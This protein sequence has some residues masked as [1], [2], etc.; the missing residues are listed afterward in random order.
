MLNQKHTQILER[1]VNVLVRMED[2][3]MHGSYVFK[4]NFQAGH[5]QSIEE[6]ETNKTLI[7]KENHG[8]NGN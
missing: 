1:F 4:I 6:I 7:R 2:A 3:Q 8:Q 5:A